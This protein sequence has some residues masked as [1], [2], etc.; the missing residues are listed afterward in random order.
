MA[1]P[2]KC[3]QCGKA[4]EV[5]DN[6]AGRKIRC[7][8]GAIV[9]VPMAAPSPSP[10]DFPP[11]KKAG[12]SGGFSAPHLGAG[13]SASV[14]IIDDFGGFGSGDATMPE[15]DL[16]FGG[17]NPFDSN[18][19]PTATSAAAT[20]ID[21]PLFAEDIAKSGGKGSG[22]GGKK[23][24]KKKGD[25]GKS[26]KSG[27]SKKSK[28]AGA[29]GRQKA[30]DPDASNFEV[31]FIDDGEDF[32]SV[33]GGFKASS[34]TSKSARHPAGEMPKECDICG[35]ELTEGAGV[36]NICGAKVMLRHP[37]ASTGSLSLVDEKD[38]NGPRG[39][40]PTIDG[41]E[42]LSDAPKSGRKSTKKKKVKGN[43][44]VEIVKSLLYPYQA[45]ASI[46]WMIVTAFVAMLAFDLFLSLLFALLETRADSM[47]HLESLAWTEF[48][49]VCVVCSIFVGYIFE[50]VENV[51]NT[52]ATGDKKFPPAPE[53]MG[54]IIGYAF[55][56]LPVF[57]MFIAIILIPMFVTAALSMTSSMMNAAIFS[58][59]ASRKAAAQA[60][61]LGF[62]AIGVGFAFLSSFIWMILM[63]A[64]MKCGGWLNVRWL[65]VP[66]AV[67]SSI[68]PVTT[69][70]GL[71]FVNAVVLALVLY[72]L[73]YLFDPILGFVF[74]IDRGGFVGQLAVK[75]LMMLMLQIPLFVYALVLNT[76]TFRGLG[77]V[78]HYD[79][80]PWSLIQ[81]R[82]LTK[83]KPKRE[84]L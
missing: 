78:M 53:F 46:M 69:A 34:P 17:G 11:P 51:L 16:G 62:L 33:A 76:A 65:Q 18:N 20:M 55:K 66:Q 9:Q 8:C 56:G 73:M 35:N 41:F 50:F 61:I 4:G 71:Q 27:K 1:V 30:A 19:L 68:G 49:V 77:L 72:V 67:I 6:F 70:W 36:C 57:I 25:T 28:K 44:Y 83:K 5:G 80:Q 43:V 79:K 63:M 39:Y 24:K 82:A 81:P 31:S 58:F 47:E 3:N 29:S 21:T 48:I 37:G 64:K 13:N 2:I 38:D 74:S 7:T 59:D 40:D 15:T 52:G 14:T 26:G 23:K 45:F 12:G 60:E 54:H 10:F 75:Y 42:D 84:P 22:E 32:G